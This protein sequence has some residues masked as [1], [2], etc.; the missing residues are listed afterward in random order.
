MR[1]SAC[2]RQMQK[3]TLVLAGAR[4]GPVCARKVLIE[5]GK[6]AP[7]QPRATETA[8]HRDDR[9]TDMFSEAV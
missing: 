4:F 9:T 6:L 2:H 8:V 7:R 5:A 3:P 1:C